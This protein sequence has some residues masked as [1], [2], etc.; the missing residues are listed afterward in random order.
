MNDFLKN[1][2]ITV[3][4]IFAALISSFLIFRADTSA[5]DGKRIEIL[6]AQIK[7]LRTLVFD[8]QDQ[9]ITL[10]NNLQNKVDPYKVIENYLAMVPYPA[11]VKEFNQ[12]YEKPVFTMWYINPSYTEMFGITRQKYYGKTDA[13]VHD[14]K[15]AEVAYLS[16][17]EVI[18]SLDYLCYH[19]IEPVGVVAT[20]GERLEG[21]VCKWPF[22]LANKLAIAGTIVNSPPHKR[23]RELPEYLRD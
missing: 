14:K 9:I 16:D 4:T 5:S 11:W 1:Q 3:L 17:K 7:E 10:K 8:Q 22:M 12:D 20:E 15:I 21:Y 19:F 23:N 13:E 18:D 6:Y 2:P